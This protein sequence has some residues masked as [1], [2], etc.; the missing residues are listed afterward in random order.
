MAISFK[1]EVISEAIQEVLAESTGKLK[2]VTG[3]SGKTIAQ[4]VTPEEEMEMKKK[5]AKIAPMEED[6]HEN[7]NDDS[8]M[9]KSQLYAIAK[10][11]LE[12]LQMIKDGDPLDAWVQAKITKAADY[13]DAVQHYLE[14]EEYLDANQG[15]S[16]EDLAEGDYQA[17]T[18]E[19]LVF[20]YLRDAWQFGAMKG[21]DVNPDEELSTMADSL[22][23]NLPDYDSAEKVEKPKEKSAFEKRLEKLAA[24]EK[25]RRANLEE[26]TLDEIKK[27]EFEK[28]K[29]GKELQ[30]RGYGVVTVVANDGIVMKIKDSL[31]KVHT[32]NLGQYNEK[33]L[34]E[35]RKRGE[36]TVRTELDATIARMKELAKKYKEGDKSVVPTLKDLTVKKKALS[37]ELEKIV[38]GIGA[39]QEYKGEVDE[40]IT[41]NKAT[42]CGKCGRTHV[43]GTECRKP[44]LTGQDHCRVR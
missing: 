38:A 4:V 34:K 36:K 33:F 39:G 16:E 35:A 8:D 3:P 7:P 41:E 11:A 5:G 2:T 14:G 18:K 1:K 43:K 21:K 6:H 9:A 23:A 19:D 32:I 40:S 29:P 20:Q 26:D 37:A 42:C 10:Y 27:A 17:R 15:E 44:F 31:D 24:A 28:I 30:L 22:L 12:L 25:E 13:V